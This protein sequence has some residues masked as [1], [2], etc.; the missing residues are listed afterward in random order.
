MS[1]FSLVFVLQNISMSVTE[2][3]LL[4]DKLSEDVLP[5]HPRRLEFKCRRA[6]QQLQTTCA[7]RCTLPMQYKQKCIH[8]GPPLSYLE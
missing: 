8:V 5:L 4:L 6:T 3:I 7:V 1:F 2:Q